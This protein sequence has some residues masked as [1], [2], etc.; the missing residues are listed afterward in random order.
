M[1]EPARTPYRPFPAFLD[2]SKQG[3]DSGTVEQ[4]ADLLRETKNVAGAAALSRAVETATKWAAVDT[5]AIEGLYEVDR[6][7]TFTVAVDAAAWANIH[8]VKGEE[9]RRAIDDALAGYDYVLDLATGAR[10]ITE[11]WVKQLHQVLCASQDTYEVLTSVGMQKHDLRKGAYKDQPNSPFNI[12]TKVIHE[13]A[14]VDDLGAEMQRLISELNSAAFLDAHAVMQAAFV[15][16]AF[17][18][19]HPFSD[20]NGRVAR[21]LAS[22][23]LYRAPGVPLVVFADQKAVYLDA[24][25]SAD[26][27]MPGNLV[28]FM[29]ERVIDTIQMVRTEMSRRPGPSLQERMKSFQ[30]SLTGRGGLLHSEIDA[31][32]NRLVMVFLASFQKH[33]EATPLEAPLS[34]GV[35]ALAGHQGAIPPGYRVVPNGGQFVQAVVHSAPP[36]TAG[37]ARFYS[38][39]VVRPDHVGPDFVLFAAPDGDVVLAP[40][41]Q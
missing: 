14:P 13:Y 35:Q 10:T 18:C 30:T 15:H 36:A 22:V 41:F 34:M 20:G 1:N 6:G 38:V 39:G 24:L 19:V 3:F 5:G 31:L 17:V 2:W 25:E 8:L 26:N 11:V 40:A 16:Y 7:F 21:A 29:A 12:R 33:L 37:V 4:F 27:D 32:A 28:E 23:Y 9:V